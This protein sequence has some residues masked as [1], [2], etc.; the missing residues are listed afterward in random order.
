MSNNRR[1]FLGWAGATAAAL[2]SPSILSA[3]ERSRGA[4]MSSAADWDMSWVKGLKGERKAVFDA[5][6]PSEGDPI[7]RSVVWGK[8]VNEVFGTP[9]ERTSRVLV[10]RHHG[11]ELAMNDAYWARFPV[12][13]DYGFTNAD[14]TS[15]PLNPVR[16]PRDEV[17]MPYRMMT[18]EAFQQSGGVV[19]ACQL[20]LQAY[21]APRFAS[22]GMSEETAMKAAQDAM[23]PG[24]VPQP[25]GIFAVS[26]AQ[27]AGCS[28]VPVS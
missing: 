15:L 12:G 24:I 4:S 9:L 17:P 27:D 16:A 1:Q 8:Q 5:P 19:L 25:S 13:S 23:L 14:G 18:L 22:T 2:A 21:V 26:V 3:T 6:A 10:L 11:I 20:A 28:Y 7:L